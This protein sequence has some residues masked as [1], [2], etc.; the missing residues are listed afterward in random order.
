MGADSQGKAKGKQ[1]PSYKGK[2][3]SKP[4]R[5]RGSRGKRRRLVVVD[6][7]GNTW[8]SERSPRPRRRSAEARARREQHFVDRTVQEAEERA[9]QEYR[10]PDDLASSCSGPSGSEQEEPSPAEGE[11]AEPPA[12]LVSRSQARAVSRLKSRPAPWSKTAR[13]VSPPAAREEGEEAEAKDLDRL[14]NISKPKAGFR[15]KP[16]PYTEKDTV[17]AR[18]YSPSDKGRDASPATKRKEETKPSAP[19]GVPPAAEKSESEN[20]ENRFWKELGALP[21]AEQAQVKPPPEAT[22]PPPLRA[23]GETIVPEVKPRPPLSVLIGWKRFI[24]EVSGVRA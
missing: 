4:F 16:S 24:E 22:P 13:A 12:R 15:G 23:E 10:A 3:K 19:A 5:P 20:S 1:K 17:R 8:V 7:H 6:E 18:A 21:A 9:Y 11:S 14:Q 2:G